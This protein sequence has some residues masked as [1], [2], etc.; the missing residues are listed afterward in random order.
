ME[1]ESLRMNSLSYGLI[2][3]MSMVLLVQGCGDSKVEK[4][5]TGAGEGTEA[6]SNIESQAVQPQKDISPPEKKVNATGA[7]TRA[8]VAEG[9]L[10]RKPS[11]AAVQREGR[12]EQSRIRLMAEK[13]LAEFKAKRQRDR[14]ERLTTDL[15]EKETELE[16]LKENALAKEREAATL[17][18]KIEHIQTAAD[19]RVAE[20]D[21]ELKKIAEELNEASSEAERLKREVDDKTGLLQAL[22]NAA[23]DAGKLKASAESELSRLRGQLD[24]TQQELDKAQGEREEFRQEIQ[25]LQSQIEQSSQE[26]DQY[27]EAAEKLQSEADQARQDVEDLRNQITKLRSEVE[28]FQPAAEAPAEKAQSRVDLILRLPMKGEGSEQA[29]NLY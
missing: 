27:R 18:T 8:A 28:A 10:D 15:E 7:G 5:Q 12:D 13:A 26:R 22:K 25:L 11:G 9:Q 16:R 21:T 24:E 2:V 20:L 17:K 6:V 14:L 23:A 29:S 4:P 19:K 3:F 1:K